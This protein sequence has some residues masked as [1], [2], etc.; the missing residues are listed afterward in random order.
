MTS[1]AAARAIIHLDMDCFYAAIEV[2]DRPELRGKPVGVGGARDRRG[3]LTTCNYEARKF[4]VHSAMPTFMALQRC[5]K[6]IVLPTR[7]DVYRRESSTIRAILHRFTPLVEPLS[8]DEAYLDV[9]A[10]PGAP[11]PLAE[12]IRKLI[13]QKTKLTASAGIGPNKL[14]AKIASD[15]KKPNGQYEVA[16]NDLAEFMAAL[17]V[18]KIW[19]IGAVTEQKLQQRGI[20]TCGDLQ[21]Y[22]RIELQNIFGKFGAELFDL[23]RGIDER[24]VEPHRERKSLSNEETFATNL[25]SLGACEEK[26]E[27]LFVELMAEL[28]QKENARTVTKIFVKL[29][30]ADFTR[31]TVERAGLLPSLGEYRKLLSEAF[32]RTGKSVRLMGVGVRFAPVAEPEAAQLSLL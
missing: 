1:G 31:T 24:P 19:G 25:E 32:A 10:H 26:L 27:E 20:N 8:L 6:L 29:K 4:G 7:F 11:G 30:F 23:S 22:S 14:V 12:V 28:A 18:R 16:P 3:V 9:S 2:R 13:F 15:L 21:R 17:P 5:P